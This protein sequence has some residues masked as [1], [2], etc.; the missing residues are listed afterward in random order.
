MPSFPALADPTGAPI[1][2]DAA[3]RRYAVTDVAEPFD[4]SLRDLENHLSVPNG[5]A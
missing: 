5:R 1:L 3:R 2:S 4:V